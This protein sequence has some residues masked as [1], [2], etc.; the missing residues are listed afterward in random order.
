[1]VSWVGRQIYSFLLIRDFARRVMDAANIE[2][3]SYKENS[4][5]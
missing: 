5:W 3:V 2:T 1:M 4:L